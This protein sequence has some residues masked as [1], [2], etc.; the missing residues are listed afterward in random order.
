MRPGVR[1]DRVPR[2]GDLPENFGMPHGVLAD[3]EKQGLG[4]LIRERLKDRR[5]VAGPRAVVESQH[6]L[7]FAQ[8]IVDFKLFEA[9]AGPAGCIDFHHAGDA[10]RIWI[11][12]ERARRGGGLGTVGRWKCGGTC[13]R[14]KCDWWR[15]WRL[16]LRLRLHEDRA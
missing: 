5:G 16:R 14:W 7:V 3:R 15:R 4:A 1:S 11:A 8:E 2:R 13:K 10:E 6:Y 12:A 9:E